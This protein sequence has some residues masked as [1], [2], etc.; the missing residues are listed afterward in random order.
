[1]P[2]RIERATPRDGLDEKPVETERGYELV[3]RRIS[4]N[5]HHVRNSTFVRSLEEAAYL[6]EQGFAI[7][8]GTPGKRPSLISPDH[9]RIVRT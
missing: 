3:D 4:K 9:L 5:R 1:M 8:M 6:V 2:V 7:R